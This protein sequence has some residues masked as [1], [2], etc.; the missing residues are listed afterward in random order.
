M[1]A[2]W[3]VFANDKSKYKKFNYQA[4]QKLAAFENKSFL[5]HGIQHRTMFVNESAEQEATGSGFVP[6]T[7]SC[8]VVDLH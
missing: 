7:L 3:G 6:V 4:K 8:F 5:S 1:N 2:H